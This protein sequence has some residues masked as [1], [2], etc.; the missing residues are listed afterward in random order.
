MKRVLLVA[1]LAIGLPTAALAS[2]IDF[3]TG[4]PFVSGTFS[5]SLTTSLTISVT[6]SM[7]TISITTGTLTAVAPGLY[8]FTGGTITVSSGATTIFTDTLAGSGAVTV[9]GT[10]VGIEAGL[11]P[12]VFNGFLIKSGIANIT[13]TLSS[14]NGVT[15]GTG[16]A[17]LATPEPSTLGLLGTGLIGLAGLTKRKLKRL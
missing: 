14:S 9:S 4:K 16:S 6:G 8:T 17:L 5:G 11:T 15:D 10:T 12:F 3:T 13:V 2:G 1:L 7:H